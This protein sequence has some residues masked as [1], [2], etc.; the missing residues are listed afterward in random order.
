MVFVPSMGDLF[1]EDVPDV[2]IDHVFATMAICGSERQTCW[3]VGCDHDERSGCWRDGDGR[4]HPRHTFQVLT[5]RPQ[6]MLEYLRS[7]DRRTQIEQVGNSPDWSIQWEEPGEMLFGAGWPLPNVWLGVSVE[8]QARANE[9]IPLLLETPAAVRFVSAEPLLGPLDID[10]YL[11][12]N[13]WHRE[14]WSSGVYKGKKHQ[15]RREPSLD[16]VIVG[17]ESGGPPERR[18]VERAWVHP[19]SPYK[20]GFQPKPKALAWVRSLRDQC[21]AAGIAFFFKQWGPRAGQGT[22]VDGREHREMP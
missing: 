15:H 21:I 20:A 3:W 8:N 10:L 5:K 2:F 4:S 18:L 6:R 7:P 12:D 14:N 17:G 1:H 13:Q 19:G 16:W 22:L 11:W 9:R